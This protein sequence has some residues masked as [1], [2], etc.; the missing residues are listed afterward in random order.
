MQYTLRREG[1]W[2]RA[3]LQGLALLEGWQALLPELGRQTA[4]AGDTRL[5]MV[6]EGLVGF[7][8]Q[9]ERQQVGELAALHLRHLAR[10]AML[11][12]PQKVTGVTEAAAR[13]RG[14]DLRV[15]SDAAQA[16]AWL[17]G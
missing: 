10:I 3:E 12:P 9:P 11:V 17:M 2:A 4:E 5:L 8:G 13:E 14:L 7:L 6:L 15:F 16:H 1:G